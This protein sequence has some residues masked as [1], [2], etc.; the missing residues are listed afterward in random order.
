MGPNN[1]GEATA[2]VT[3]GAPPTSEAG[4]VIIRVISKASGTIVRATSGAGGA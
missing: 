3:V 4:K 2:T 1:E